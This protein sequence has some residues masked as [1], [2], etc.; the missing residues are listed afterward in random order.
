M[1]RKAA[2]IVDACRTLQGAL[3]TGSYRQLLA[4]FRQRLA[5]STVVRRAVADALAACARAVDAT[6]RA[7]VLH[8]TRNIDGDITVTTL[9]NTAAKGSGGVIVFMNDADMYVRERVRE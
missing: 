1:Q 9:M 6:V 5:L 4:F 7:R 2:R 3:G 8:P